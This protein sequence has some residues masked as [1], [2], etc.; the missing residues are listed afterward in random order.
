MK[1]LYRAFAILGFVGATLSLT[2][3]VSAQ[4]ARVTHEAATQLEKQIN[5]NVVGL[6]NAGKAMFELFVSEKGSW[7]VVVSEPNGRICI[8]ACGESWQRLPP[9][10]GDPA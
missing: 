10:I 3:P 4:Q 5:E 9:L 1:S 7:T 2:G 6:A 8:L